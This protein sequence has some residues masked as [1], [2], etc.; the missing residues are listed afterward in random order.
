MKRVLTGLLT[1]SLILI[2]SQAVFAEAVSGDTDVKKVYSAEELVKEASA[3]D[4]ASYFSLDV[5][6]TPDNLATDELTEEVA[7]IISGTEKKAVKQESVAE[8][9]ED[10]GF[11]TAEPSGI[12]EVEVTA[13]YS[14]QRIL[15]DAPY[16]SELNTYGANAAVFY[17][18][19]YL[20]TYDSEEATK[21]AYEALMEEY[22]EDAVLLDYP[23]KLSATGWGTAYMGM[24]DEQLVAASGSDVTVAVL[25]SGINRNHSIFSNTTILTGYDYENGDSDPADDNGHGTA[26]AGVIA[27]STPS[28]VKI[29]P[30]KV[31]DSSGEGS[32]VNIIYGMEYAVEQGADVI[33]LSLG[34]NISSSREFRQMSSYF[35]ETYSGSDIVVV[36][37]A[38]NEAYNMDASRKNVFPAEVESTICVGAFTSS[39]SIASF[40]NYGSAVDL[41]APGV[42]VK[43]ADYASTTGYTTMSGTSF[44]SPYVAAAAALVRAEYP[45]LD[46]SSVEDKLTEIAK[47]LGASGKDNYF[48]NGCPVFTQEEDPA[49]EDPEEGETAVNIETAENVTISGIENK[50]YTGSAITQTPVVKIG[51]T[52]LTEGTDYDLTYENNVDAGTAKITI[53]GKG[54]YTGSI[55]RTFAISA[56]AITPSIT[57]SAT[58]YTYD[59]TTKTPSVTVYDGSSVLSS[60]DYDA[61]YEEG[62]IN[63]GTYSVIVT[64]KGNYS[65]SASK[66]F[67]ISAKSI[68]P[69]I[70]LS[71]DSY[72]YDGTQKTP[73]VTVYDGS[74]ALSSGDYMVTYQD[75]R[76]NAGTYTVSVTLKGN[77]TGSE[78]ASYDISK[79]GNSMSVSGKTAKVKYRKLKKKTQK[80]SVSKVLNL[81]GGEGTITYTKVS[82][83]KKITI[84]QATGK[85]KIKKKLRKGTYKVYVKVIAAGDANYNPA[86]T[87]VMIRI[88]VK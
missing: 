4:N 64:M 51:D 54:S 23:V 50:T 70:V 74:K 22:G 9:L 30:V 47:D 36:C 16:S 88:K 10:S 83:N 21:T 86:E 44:S 11:Y 37:A 49:E 38:G 7:E 62:R 33:N 67:D 5:T 31:M 14:N 58:S 19:H 41:S 56:K 24:D 32:S 13:I 55:S 87:T 53:T 71:N 12:S 76:V 73:A 34:G 15:L 42:S 43:L 65:G 57:L 81:S 45:S 26:V 35:T 39:E 20:L 18:D 60:S 75:G 82:G 52:V 66:T 2:A 72:I 78:S 61:A 3:A 85:V 48:G 63:A 46:S 27:E 17:D 28:N 68:T 80:L 84:N 40:S 77:Y 25:D 1:L 8:A 59:G 69:T 6:E 29:L 79:A